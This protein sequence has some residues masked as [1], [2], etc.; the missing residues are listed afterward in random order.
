MGD[1]AEVFLAQSELAEGRSPLYARLWREF[2][3]DSGVAEIVGPDPGWDAPL[4]LSGGL[5]YLVLT[6]RARWD[7]ADEAIGEYRDFLREW[8]ANR[9]V[10]TNE[11]QRCWMLLPCFLEAARRTGATAFDLVEIGPSAGL[12]LVWD[13]YRYS[14]VAGNWGDPAAGL[15]L[16]GREERLV[17]AP[18]L[19]LHPEIRSR[20][21]I[22]LSPIDVT[23]ENDALRLKSFVWADQIERVER[24]DAA[25]RRGEPPPGP[26]RDRPIRRTPRRGVRP[27]A[28]PVERRD[29]AL[30]ADA[31]ALARRRARRA[32]PRHPPRRVARLGRRLVE[33][34]ERT[35]RERPHAL[36]RG[37]HRA[38]AEAASRQRGEI[39]EVLADRDAGGEEGR[40]D[41]SLAR[42]RCRRCSTSRSR[43]ARRRRPAGALPPRR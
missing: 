35:H 22:D 34:R 38:E 5:H 3:H 13:R 12:N 7:D 28:A 36:H 42:S 20:T 27:D 33:N 17:P 6:G 4:R 39:G 31:P 29:E 15:Y 24:L 25:L 21:G 8:V 40:V 9:R 30:R 1:H 10:Q 23:S 2:A 43:R 41:G 37:G 18:L 16:R 19:E 14:Y 11:V 32:R 26:R